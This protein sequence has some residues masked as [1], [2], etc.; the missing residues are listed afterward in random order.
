MARKRILPPQCF[1]S[2]VDYYEQF[3]TEEEKEYDGDGDEY[4]NNLIYD[5]FAPWNYQ[6]GY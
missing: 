3:E 5:D 2:D 4:D 1:E 6:G